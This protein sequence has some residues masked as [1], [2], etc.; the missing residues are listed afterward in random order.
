MKKAMFAS[1]VGI[2]ILIGGIGG[3]SHYLRDNF[4]YFPLSYKQDDITIH[5]W[6][7]Y[8]KPIKLELSNI[9]SGWKTIS[10]NDS[11]E[12]KFVLNELKKSENRVV[13]SNSNGKGRHFILTFFSKGEGQ[14]AKPLLQF[15]GYEDGLVNVNNGKVRRMTEALN[16]YIGKKL[17]EI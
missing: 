9:D 8:K 5:N 11:I 7:K 2:L 17:N 3:I 16:N 12:Q 4:L 14:K 13:D 6:T 15:D 10:I 1:L